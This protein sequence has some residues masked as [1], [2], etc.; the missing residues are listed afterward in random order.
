MPQGHP[1]SGG[2]RGSICHLSHL[3]PLS[4]ALTPA[5]PLHISSVHLSGKVSCQ[6]LLANLTEVVLWF[7]YGS[8]S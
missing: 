6:E 5:Y 4:D 2:K 1:S 7:S 3:L 8:W